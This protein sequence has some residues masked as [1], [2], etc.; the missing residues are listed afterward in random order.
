MSAVGSSASTAISTPDEYVR[1]KHELHQ[2]RARTDK[3]RIEARQL[4]SQRDGLRSDVA[5]ESGEVEEK[6]LILEETLDSIKRLKD[7][8]EQVEGEKDEL[9]K[10]VEK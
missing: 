10:K 8:I 7:Q 6:R 2:T 5:K 9:M 4:I 1:L 3:K